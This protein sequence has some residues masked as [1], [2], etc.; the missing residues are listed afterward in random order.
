[1]TVSTSTVTTPPATIRLPKIRLGSLWNFFVFVVVFVAVATPLLFLVLGSFSQARLPSE[2]SIFNLSLANYVKVWSDPGTYAVINN[3]L[4]F[5]CGST[6]VGIILAAGLAWLVERTN[7]PGKIW[8]YA[9]VPMTLAMPGMLQSM[10][11]VLLASPPN[12]LY[13]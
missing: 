13:Q 10:A 4:I 9:G 1:M 2:F 5:A 8:I 3:T 6:A 12:R 7:I 11:W